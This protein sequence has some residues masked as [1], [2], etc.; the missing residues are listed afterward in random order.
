MKGT[1]RKP[2]TPGGSWSYRLD[3]GYDDS[4]EAPSATGGQFRNEA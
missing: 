2:R 4:G 3:L 1:L